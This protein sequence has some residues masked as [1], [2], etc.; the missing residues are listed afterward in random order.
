MI[1]QLLIIGLLIS[2][3][4][5][6]KSQNVSINDLL[7]A[8]FPSSLVKAPDHNKIAFV[9]NEEGVRNIWIAEG[10]KFIPS[11]ITSF[12]VDRGRNISQLGFNSNGNALYYRLGDPPNRNGEYPNPTSHPTYK[13]DASEIFK[14]NLTDGS[15]RSL[16]KGTKGIEAIGN[17]F[18]IVL[19]KG[20]LYN[21]QNNEE[22]TAEKWFEVRGSISEFSVSPASTNVAFTSNR[23]DHSFVGIYDLK[24]E[25][26]EWIDPSVDND[27]YLHWSP[28]GTK[29]AFLRIPSE[30]D[31]VL[32]TPVREAEPWSIMVYDMQTKQ[33][34]RIWTAPKGRGSAFRNVSAK[35]QLYWTCNDRLVFPYEG[36]G[37]TNLYSIKSDGS[38]LSNISNGEFEVQYVNYDATSCSIFYS[39]NQDDTD[40]QHIWKYDINTEIKTQ[41]TSGNGI[42]WAPV[43]SK[44]G[45]IF[46]LRSEAN[47]PSH[48]GM[49]KDGKLKPIWPSSIP[50]AFSDQ[51]LPGAEQVIFNAPDGMKIHGQLFKPKNIIPGQK[52]PAVLF[53]HGGS[54][55]Q[56]LLG[57]HHRG[58]YHNMY[59]LNQYMASKGYIVL[60]VNFRSG[61]GYGMEFREALNYGANGASEYNDVLGGAN[62][63]KSRNDVDHD[64]IGLYGGS[65]GGYLTALGLAK[66]SDVFAVGVDIHGVHDWNEVIKNFVPSYNPQKLAAAAKMA[67][68]S[69]PMHFMD[70]WRSPVLLIH[71]D[72]DRNVPFSE[73]VDLAEQ[74]RKRNVYFEQLIFPDEVHGFLLHENWQ[75]AMNAAFDFFERFLKNKK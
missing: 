45:T 20:E 35:S 24:K 44:D 51:S 46:C 68:E 5:E 21:I 53:F 58:Y 18:D 52:L 25:K 70:G 2:C 61:I 39:S 29:L 15:I 54:R 56:M 64:K 72:D 67:Y 19:D 69:S 22:R 49:V 8:P 6:L 31:R 62:Y 36:N 71:G 63:L 32:F 38:Q 40:R 60:S 26:I 17:N 50:S 47:T 42:E 3:M 14:I 27:M 57:Y 13:N 28:D 30:K 75:K 59:A 65:Y 7:S 55:R 37:F 48:V 34:E 4:N 74:L 23:G 12:N 10:P 11:K 43:Q 73:T 9:L 1:R 16:G 33:T 66:D 41:V